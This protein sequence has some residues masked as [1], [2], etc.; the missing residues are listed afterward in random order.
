MEH[1]QPTAVEATLNEYITLCRAVLDWL[2]PM[3]TPVS[4]VAAPKICE[5]TLNSCLVDWAACKP[6][7]QDTIVYVLQLQSRNQE[8]TQVPMQ[9]PLVS[10]R[11]CVVSM[12]HLVNSLDVAS[13]LQCSQYCKM[14]N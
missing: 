9:L 3:I 11:V 12:P 13:A 14:C 8:Y 7:G 10:T 4:L 2:H 1:L 6:M 5:V